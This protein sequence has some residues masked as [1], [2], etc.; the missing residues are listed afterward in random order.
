MRRGGRRLT[1]VMQTVRC[2]L[3]DAKTYA[4]FVAALDDAG[5]Q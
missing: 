4:E 2:L 1:H 5:G 3:V